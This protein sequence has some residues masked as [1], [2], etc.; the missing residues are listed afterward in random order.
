MLVS[1]ILP[2]CYLELLSIDNVII[3]II[4]ISI[5]IGIV[6]GMTHELLSI[7]SWGGSAFLSFKCFEDVRGIA[8]SY[9]SN[10]LIAD[11]ITV[12]ALFVCFLLIISII[13]YF[14]SS[15][16]KKSVFGSVDRFFGAVFGCCRGIFIVCV[17]CLVANQWFFTDKQP[18]IVEQS[19]FYP[20]VCKITNMCITC[21]PKDIQETLITHMSKLNKESIA[22]FVSKKVDENINTDIDQSDDDLF[23]S[24]DSKK[25]ETA[26]DNEQEAERLA[27]LLPSSPADII[28]DEDDDSD[29]SEHLSNVTDLNKLSDL[30]MDKESKNEEKDEDA[31]VSVKESDDEQ[32]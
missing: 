12:C 31:L 11:S 26:R 18:V 13:N 17:A 14:C 19:K 1:N 28:K 25:S 2:S 32:Q 29:T 30:V 7:A 24:A 21:L 10:N 16:I 15:F 3:L 8:R 23:V 5:I 4:A 22:D 6:R 20:I 27:N 9:V